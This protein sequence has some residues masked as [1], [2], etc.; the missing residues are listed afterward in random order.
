MSESRKGKRFTEETKRKLS[1]IHKG[2]RFSAEH[3]RKLSEANRDSKLSQE[4]IRRLAEARK[5]THHTEETKKRI[6][7]SER[8]RKLSAE[9]RRKISEANKGESHYNWRGGVSFLPYCH[10][11]NEQLKEGIRDRDNRTCQLCNEKENGRK[12]TVHHIHYDKAN[13]DPDLIALCV[14]CSGKVNF[15]RDYYEELFMERLKERGL[16]TYQKEGDEPIQPTDV[17]LN[18]IGGG[19]LSKY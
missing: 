8:G 2:R 9:H 5:G 14:R 1:D 3:R 19:G 7:Q 11:F 13:C 18:K 17:I 10:K 6:S 16:L 12:L 15:N 4:N